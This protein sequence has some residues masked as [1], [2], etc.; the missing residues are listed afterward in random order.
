MPD[1]T[2]PDFRTL[3][4]QHISLPDNEIDLQKAALCLAGEE[5]PDLD[6]EGYLV[7]LDEIAGSI[8]SQAGTKPDPGD[9]ARALN[10]YLFE[11]EGYSGNSSDYYNPENSFLNRVMDTRV[12]IP[13]TLSVLYLGVA[14]RLGLK[15]YGVG[16]PG[17]FLVDVQELDLY[18]D[19]YHSGQ[20]LSASDCRRLAQSMLGQGIEWSDSFLAPTPSKM[21][22]AR[23]LNNLRHIYSHGGDLD[24]LTSVLERMLLID[25]SSVP[26]YK[27]LVA[28]Q[29]KMGRTDSAVRSLQ[30]LIRQ[31][32]DEQEIAA[33]KSLID[34]LRRERLTGY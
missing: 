20:L 23:M 7:R 30:S 15:C 10:H 6:V 21:V 1:F 27:E 3:F 18:M 8:R 19:P 12:G 17:H 31:S 32:S 4:A 25:E 2:R 11:A 34:R 33:A 9:L 24:Q 26:L 16:M 29:I 22:L 5:F 13:I 28:C 14:K